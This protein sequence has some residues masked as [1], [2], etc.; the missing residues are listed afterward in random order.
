MHTQGVRY[1]TANSLLDAIKLFRQCLCELRQQA[2]FGSI[3]SSLLPF[4]DSVRLISVPVLETCPVELAMTGASLFRE[5]YL[6]TSAELEGCYP[7]LL[8]PKSIDLLTMS[9]IYNLALAHQLRAMTCPEKASLNYKRAVTLYRSTFGHA[10]LAVA[11]RDDSLGS[12]LIAAGC[13]LCCLFAENLEFASME[14]CMEWTS[15]LA[16]QQ[17]CMHQS[18]RVLVYNLFFW[19]CMPSQPAAAA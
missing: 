5:A 18:T 12:I 6:V 15:Q 2:D 1:L 8:S 3:E 13:N 16:T 14:A 9:T 17:T 19:E 10:E 11:Q 4:D 7:K